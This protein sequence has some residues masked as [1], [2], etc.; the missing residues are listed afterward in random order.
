M[1][2][3]VPFTRV[4]PRVCA[5]VGAAADFVDVSSDDEAYWC[6]LADLWAAGESFTVV[7]HDIVVNETA[8]ASLSEC[9]SPWC[10]CA[11]PYKGVWLAGMGC[12][13]FS[14]SLMAAFPTA[15]E[16]AGALS[17]PWHPRKHWC[18]LDMFLQVT[19]NEAGY[20]RC[21]VHPHVDHLKPGRSSHGCLEAR[22]S[23]LT[24]V[25]PPL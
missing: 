16:R 15:V 11:Y 22:D 2:I 6:L 8:L 25:G 21:D 17:D 13:K 20:R 9:E 10:A 1:R 3:V 24:A 23:G 5:A 14:A 4:E 12:T 18:S 7:E 19:L